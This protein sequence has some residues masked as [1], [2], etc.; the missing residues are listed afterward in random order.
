[1][2]QCSAGFLHPTDSPLATP[3]PTAGRHPTFVPFAMF[4]L[5]V[6]LS[7][8]VKSGKRRAHPMRPGISP[9]QLPN[10]RKLVSL[11]LPRF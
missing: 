1:M 6:G 10:F 4:D 3:H 8:A 9:H 11:R 2:P 5:F 7:E